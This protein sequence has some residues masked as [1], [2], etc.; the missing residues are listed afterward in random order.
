MRIHVNHIRDVHE[1]TTTVD[2]ESKLGR[3]WAHWIGAIPDENA[4]YDVELEVPDI[5]TWGLEITETTASD[6]IFEKEG[7]VC[8]VGRVL[9][10]GDDG[11]AAIR[12]RD[13][14]VLVE[15][16]DAPRPIPRCVL[17][18]IPRLELCDARL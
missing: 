13:D 5:L 16:A 6:S 18:R 17:I 3:A 2:F 11:V 14:I 12:L 7:G 4:D 1:G 8:L 10:L 15:I 9:S